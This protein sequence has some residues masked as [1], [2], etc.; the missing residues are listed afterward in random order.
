MVRRR[1][2]GRPWSPLKL[3]SGCD[4]RCAFCAIPSFRGSFV[5][6]PPADVLA[7]ARWLCGQGV[8]ELLLVS[9]N[10]TSYGKDLGDVRLLE[11]LLPQLAG[12]DGVDRVRVSYLQPAELRPGLV[13]VIAGTAG[14][15]PYFDLSFQHAA[16]QLLRRMRRFGGSADFLELI[17][18]IRALAP[19]AGI[20]S[21]VIVGFPGES[22]Q[23][24]RELEEFLEAARLDVVG[25]FGYSDE[26]GTEAA[27]LPGKLPPEQVSQ[28]VSRVSALVEELSAQRAEDRIGE[29]VEVLVEELDDD[30]HEGPGTGAGVRAVGR[31][32]HQGP[33]VDGV[34]RLE[35]ASR[36][37]RPAGPPRPGELVRAV[38]VAADGPDL[39]ARPVPLIA[40]GAQEA[41]GE[42]QRRPSRF[43]GRS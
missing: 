36:G 33:E 17:A 42:R 15:A 28:R 38:V 25:V 4:R 7:E 27:G 18:R 16:P 37:E 19:T 32:A 11:S 43:A 34:T 8:R 12:L 5:S 31:A 20:R 41:A 24:L 23:E 39:L 13:E 29:I 26:E 3:A 21:N 6:R 9:E 14:V 30:D 40:G 2:D 35:P 22:E 1:L 10:S